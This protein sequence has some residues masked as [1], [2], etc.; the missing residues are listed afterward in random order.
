C[1]PTFL[2]RMKKPNVCVAVYGAENYGWPCLRDLLG[3]IFYPPSAE[4]DVLL[5]HNLP[6]QRADLVLNDRIGR[7]REDV[8]RSNQEE[9]L[10]QVV[11][12]PFDC[13]NDLLIRRRA[14][15]HDVRGEL[16]PFVLYRIKQE[17]VVPFHHRPDLLSTCGSPRPK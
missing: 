9:T 3:N 15:V 10:P 16:Q 12:T 5:A 4:K 8:I 7:T 11:K 1:Q 17:L 2:E 6:L 13:R 14:C